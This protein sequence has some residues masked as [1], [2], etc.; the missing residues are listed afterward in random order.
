[1]THHS[2]WFHDTGTEVLTADG[3]P[4]KIIDFLHQDDEA[5]L[6]LW[7]KHFREHYIPDTE[8]DGAR[9]PMRLSRSD[10]LKDIKFPS[11]PHVRSGEH[12]GI[13]IVIN[14]GAHKNL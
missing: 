5:I 14:Y 2:S 1:M 4:V 8:I 11:K 13:I 10:Y 3:K 9:T 6:K 12:V 7:A